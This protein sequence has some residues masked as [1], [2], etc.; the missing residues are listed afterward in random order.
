MN[1]LDEIKKEH[2]E[3]KK[4]MKEIEDGKVDKKTKFKELSSKI[5]AHHEAE[6]KVVFADIKDKADEKSKDVVL[7]MI[8]EHHLGEYQ[9]DVVS[10]TSKDDETW[11]AKFAV[12]KEVVEHHIEEEEEDLFKA[13]TKFFTKEELENKYEEFE[14]ISD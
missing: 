5:A 12:F 8:E 13:A 3:F 9:A 2:K 4:M 10:K 14:K 7:E 11:D 6:E 1:V